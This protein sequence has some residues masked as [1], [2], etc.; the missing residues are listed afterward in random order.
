L[1]MSIKKA[2]LGTAHV[3]LGVF[4]PAGAAAIQRKFQQLNF[5][6]VH[7]DTAALVGLN[8]PNMPETMPIA[9]IREFLNRED[10]LE[11]CDH[12]DP[13][14]HTPVPPAIQLP[15]NSGPIPRESNH[16]GQEY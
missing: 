13:D 16:H 8:E 2:Y 1:Q 3:F 4:M 5:Q 6:H 14:G 15:G 9:K 12:C 7:Y 10:A 11:V